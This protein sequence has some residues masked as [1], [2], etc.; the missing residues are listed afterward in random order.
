[1]INFLTDSTDIKR[2]HFSSRLNLKQR[3]EWGQ[4][5]TPAPIARFMAGQ[6]NNLTGHIRLLDPGAGVGALTSAFVEQLLLNPDSVKSCLITA[7][8]IESSFLSSLHQCL[9]E[10]CI[11]LEKQGIQADYC[12]H[13]KSFI[14][15]AIDVNLPLLSETNFSETNTSFTHAILNPPYK[16][17]NSQSLEKK[18]LSSLGI[19]TGNLYSAFVWLSLLQLEQ[20]GEIVAITPRSFCNGMYFRPFR[21]ALLQEMRLSKVHVFNSRSAAFSDDDVLQENIIFHASKTKLNPDWV[22]VTNH[23]GHALDEFSETRLVAYDQVIE[24]KD[25]EQFIHIITNSLKWTPKAGQF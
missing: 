14:D 20:N 24:L 7:Y 11:A 13:E 25:S 22:A 3:R 18:L 8:E 5:L 9:T 23:S 1:M 16:K 15:A 10:C 19:E 17:I 21:K 12:L 2:F 6:F 4:F